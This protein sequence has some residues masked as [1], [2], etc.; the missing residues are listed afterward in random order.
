MDQS[1]RSPH[2][3]LQK[4]S[5][6]RKRLSRNV[7]RWTAKR[8]VHK[9]KCDELQQ[10]LEDEAAIDTTYL[11]LVFGSCAIATFGLLS[12]SAA[13]IIGAMIIAPL[14]LPI[15][16]MAFGALEGEPITVEKGALAI[17]VGTVIAVLMACSIGFLSGIAEYGSEVW[18]RSQ[19][20][21]LDLGVAVTA[22][23]ISGF[24]KVQPKISSA[25]AGTAISVAL[26]PPL[27]VIG[28]GLA[29]AD[30]QLSM[31]AAL[32]F[33]TNLLGI[34][35]SCM[36]AF[37][38]T[39]YTPILRARRGLSIAFGVTALLLL[40]LGI[41][42]YDLVLQSQLER[43]VRTALL[44]RTITLQRV[45]LLQFET[46]WFSDPPTVRLL[47]VTEEPLTSKQV[48]L[49]E[50]FVALEMERPFEL[51]FEIS[52]VRQV[53]REPVLPGGGR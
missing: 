9:S 22:G 37:L 39:G 7:Y 24:A 33:A 46:N 2:P 50:E 19:P 3:S 11:V 17:A 30:W 47:V 26:M 16:C 1:K 4:L 36:V 18:A 43:S 31:G 10:S 20:N 38:L 42:F 29:H 23:G 21:L 8:R 52:Q 45:E 27:C 35:L 34:T 32:L 14:M 48:R 41:S 12:N 13:V 53:R 15:R 6:R 25:L 49:M 51:V 5:S 44:D 28:L 40:P